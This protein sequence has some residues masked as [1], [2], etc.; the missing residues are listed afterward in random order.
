[1]HLRDRVASG[2]RAAKCRGS[3]LTV[4]G[5]VLRPLVDRLV[6]GSTVV[7]DVRGF[8]GEA[9]LEFATTG[10]AASILGGILA[11]AHMG[12][13]AVHSR[14]GSRDCGGERYRS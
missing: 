1:M 8:P 3:S 7:G 10:R 2:R 11:F 6:G 14:H 4:P 12:D 5:L 9:Q 13:G